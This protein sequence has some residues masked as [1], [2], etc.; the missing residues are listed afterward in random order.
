MV[1]EWLEVFLIC[2]EKHFI[3]NTD[4]YRS[5]C[6]FDEIMLQNDN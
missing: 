6:C 4:F 5:S 1:R 2:L 3:I